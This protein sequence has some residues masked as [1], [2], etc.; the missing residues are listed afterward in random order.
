M[1]LENKVDTNTM[2]K[3]QEEKAKEK[4]GSQNWS[5]QQLAITTYTE[6]IYTYTCV[7]ILQTKLSRLQFW[8]NPTAQQDNGNTPLWIHKLLSFLVSP[9]AVGRVT[10]AKVP[11]ILTLNITGKHKTSIWYPTPVLLP[12]KSHGRRSLVGCSPWSH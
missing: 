10:S 3:D 5:R 4:W 9:G 6:T 7:P 1:S 11:G 2:M 8:E 12:G